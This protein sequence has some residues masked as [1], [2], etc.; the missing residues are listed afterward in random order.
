MNLRA[1][2]AEFIGTFALL[3][4]VVGAIASKMEPLGVVLANGIVIAAMIAALGTAS[5]A[6]FNPAVTLGLLLT[7]RIALKDAIFYWFSQ[8]LGA[9]L[10]VGLL[11]L[12]LGREAMN[13]VA[14]GVPRLAVGVSP[15]AGFLVEATLAFF[16]VLVIVATAIHL[17]N[18]YA[19]T[20][21]GL[22][23]ALGVLCGGNIT[24]AT[25]NPARAFGSA[26]WGGGFEHGW[27]YWVGPLLGGVLGTLAADY[28][29][30]PRIARG[31]KDGRS[32]TVEG[33]VSV[34]P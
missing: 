11:T 18:P 4:V 12:A 3:F 5:G 34:Q 31:V 23:V 19:A 8:L 32:E 33:S 9:S 25:M 10:A 7:R 29:Y 22:A 30:G 14:Y 28:M 2:L 6:H 15:L 16:L 20:Y 26:I 24:G 27:V 21:I 13:G 1:Y 17:K